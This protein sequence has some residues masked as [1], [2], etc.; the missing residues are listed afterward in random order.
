MS[1]TPFETQPASTP[2][3]FPSGFYA[4]ASGYK[5]SF[6]ILIVSVFLIM[7]I[8]SFDFG[9]TWD[10]WMDS[11]NG[12]LALR[13]LLSGGQDKEFL[14]FW[15][16]IYYSHLFYGITGLLYGF[17]FDSVRNFAQAGLHQD[18]HLLNFYT[19]SHVMNAL[20]GAL[21]ILSAGLAAKKMGTWRSA[22]FVALF[23][24]LSPRFLGHSMNN[25]KDIPF[26]STYMLALLSMLQ[27]V[28]ELP[29]PRKRTLIFVGLTIA[30]AIGT[31]IGGFILLFYVAL[32]SG[33]AWLHAQIQKSERWN[34]WR[35]LG[36]LFMVG[37]IAY[38][39]GLVFWPYGQMNPLINTFKAI[40]EIT[41]FTHWDNEVLFEGVMTQA[42]QL[43]WYYIPKWILISVPLFIPAGLILFALLLPAILKKY[44]FRLML[45]VLFSA[46]FPAAYVILKKSIV[47][48]EWRHLLF[49]YAP[50]VILAASSWDFLLG[51][52]KNAGQRILIWS[53][54]F[55][56]MIAPLQWMVRNHP[57]QYV[58]FNT[59]AGGLQG[60]F[61]NYEMDYWGNCV[62][63][64]SEWLA[65]YHR[66]HHPNQPMFVRS[67]GSVMSSYPF[68]KKRL[69][70][71]YHPFGY[72]RQFTEKAPYLYF[73]YGPYLQGPRGWDYAIVISRG[74]AKDV[75]KSPRGWPPAGTI[76]EVKADNT[77]L[78]AVVKNPVAKLK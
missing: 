67:D 54:L 72:P 52:T 38:A 13:Y 46:L 75:L 43:P 4:Q 40:K 15:H 31:R 26:A 57:N 68:L 18:T 49:I 21:T 71:L 32:F 5:L 53:L 65:D 48:D 59:L 56:H 50:L 33:G 70:E 47:Y 11:N 76:Y 78:C 34:P 6:W 61:G 51:L 66:E 73:G 9:I 10:E 25:P 55:A 30:L 20:F 58:Y 7:P 44:D 28:E 12:M 1:Q 16:G 2:G 63:S 77:T 45:M 22:C 36:S 60:A 29:S 74:W 39:G 42:S 62:R 14:N 27:F 23:M 24:V 37:C 8:L 41:K 17:I 69:G 3:S 35:I 64:A 19:T